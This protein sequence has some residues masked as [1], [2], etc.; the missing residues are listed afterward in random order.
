M[1]LSTTE[2]NNYIS[3]VKIR[4]F[5]EGS[6]VF[7]VTIT[8]NNKPKDF[9]G[10]TPF[11]CVKNGDHIGLGISEQIVTDVDPK[12]GKLRYTLKK[13][14]MQQLG[15]PTAYFSFRE[16]KKD[17]LFEWHTQFS[18]KDF[19]YTVVKSIYG[20][21]I[22]DSNYI[23]TFEEIL[24]YF[25][26]WVEESMKTYDDWY[27][28]AQEELQ[29]IIKEFQSWIGKNQKLY[30]D[31][32][33][34]QKFDF[35]QWQ[36]A[37]KDDFVSWFQSLKDILNENAAGNLQNQLD[38]IRPSKEIITINHN[39][40]GYPRLRVLYWEY[41]MATRS[42]A[43]EPTG[44]GG[45]NVR[46]VESSVEYLDPY[47]LKVSVPDAYRTI[48]PEFVFID[49]KRF[50]L[51]S[52]YKVI[53]V[54]LLEDDIS[55]YVEVTQ[56]IDFKNKIPNSL[57][58][59][60]HI[61]RRTPYS[62]VGQTALVT[63]PNFNGTLELGATE[64]TSISTLDNK[65]L[66]VSIKGD[67]YITQI[68]VAF[69]LITDI[70]RRYPGLFAEHGATTLAQKVTVVKN[71]ISG[72]TIDLHGYGS[73]VGGNKLTVKRYQPWDKA[74]ESG[75]FVNN[76]NTIKKI[77][78]TTGGTGAPYIDNDGNIQGIVYAPASDGVTPSV[79]NLDYAS[80]EYTIK[81]GGI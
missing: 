66:N 51:I 78:V 47:S 8:E 6:Q 26:Q 29:R 31:W 18:T 81:A 17:S 58:E 12:N 3:V 72:L 48:D 46:T 36:N 69:D 32:L 65:A 20:D 14:D 38:E 57:A 2:P 22:K 64:Y 50:R 45:G 44:L 42:L 74:Y 5:D 4:Q 28:K 60:P 75:A 27:I 43:T 70:D 59:N 37:N 56:T 53:Q 61:A 33:A 41:G 62:G 39:F 71:I 16:K 34:S 25:Q 55:G 76:T 9:T 73:G 67:K 1:I 15:E 11:F 35:D 13:S 49:N 54:E 19:S 30:D 10:L 79:V 77:S 21:G 24:R 68:L 80:L 23:W 52:D 40:K 7:D 63:P